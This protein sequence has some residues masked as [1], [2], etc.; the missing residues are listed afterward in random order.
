MQA[1][2][3]SK[4]TVPYPC[5]DLQLDKTHQGNDEHVPML[6]RSAVLLRRGVADYAVSGGEL[7]EAGSIGHLLSGRET[8]F[9]TDVHSVVTAD[10]CG[11]QGG[12]QCDCIA[13]LQ[14]VLSHYATRESMRTYD[15]PARNPTLARTTARYVPMGNP[16]T[17]YGELPRG[18]APVVVQGDNGTFNNPVAAQNSQNQQNPPT[19]PPSGAPG[20]NLPDPDLVT[21]TLYSTNANGPKRGNNNSV[22]TDNECNSLREQR[23]STFTVKS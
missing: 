21:V 14:P 22:K 13:A 12:G 16:N 6:S 9:N 18:V 1:E 5:E 3:N 4:V 11:G 17:I 7:H 23:A 2:S 10:T 15:S 8:A 19:S 20:E